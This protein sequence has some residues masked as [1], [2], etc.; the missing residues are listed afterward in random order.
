[1]PANGK[2]LVGDA[3]CVAG[4]DENV[5]E[6][7]DEG[8]VVKDKK[9]DGDWCPEGRGSKNGNRQASL[10]QHPMPDVAQ[11]QIHLHFAQAR[12]AGGADTFRLFAKSAAWADTA[13]AKT[14]R[15][16]RNPIP[17]ILPA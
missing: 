16:Q 11:Q 5:S 14:R 13:M 2:A 10:P 7:E 4:D 17:E 9:S 8:M 3:A 12:S 15:A 1:M 6:E